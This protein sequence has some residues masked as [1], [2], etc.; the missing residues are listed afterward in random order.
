MRRNPY[1][2]KVDEE[3]K[4]LP[5]LDEFVYQKGPT[6]TGRSLCTMAGGCDHSNLEN[7]ASEFV[8]TLKRAQEPDAH[9]NV[10]WGP[11][12]LGFHVMINQSADYGA[13]DEK[14][15]AMRELIRNVNFRRAMS[16][17]TDRDGIAQATMRGPFLRAYAGGLL[18]GAPEFDREAVVYWAYAPDS[19]KKLLSELGFEDTDGNGILNWTS[20]PMEGE[21]L[22]IAMTAGEDQQEAVNIAEALD[23]VASGKCTSSAL[24]RNLL[25]PFPGA[26]TWLL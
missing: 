21:D 16:Q 1:Y 4:Q 20:G 13:K 11:E 5:Y 15:L 14:D 22:A 24:I 7:P 8:E 3:G 2:W 19:A 26:A 25:C 6:G 9:F 10:S 23:K 12:L 17:A 18:P